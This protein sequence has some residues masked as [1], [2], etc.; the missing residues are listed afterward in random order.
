MIL[1]ESN[2]AD[3]RMAIGF[4]DQRKP[5]RTRTLVRKSINTSVRIIS[6]AILFTRRCGAALGLVHRWRPSQIPHKIEVRQL[7]RSE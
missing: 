7:F 2:V 5:Q 6:L 4:R 1:L 3:R